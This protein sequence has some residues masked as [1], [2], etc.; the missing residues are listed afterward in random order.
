MASR[1]PEGVG[2]LVLWYVYHLGELIGRR[3]ALILLFELSE[4]LVYLVQRA[5]LV[6]RKPDYA[7]L[8]REGLEYRLANPPYGV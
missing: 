1:N 4:G 2:Y 8:L 5:H 6:E 3:L 7:A